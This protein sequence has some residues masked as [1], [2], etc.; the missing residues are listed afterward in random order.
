MKISFVGVKGLPYCGG[1]ERFTEEVGTRLVAKGHEVTVYTMRHYGMQGGMFQGMH[2]RTVPS[3]RGRSLEKLTSSFMASLYESFGGNAD[4]VHFHAFGPAAFCFIPRLMNRKVVV[5]G[6]GIEWQRSKWGAAGKLLLRLLE[7]PSVRFP[8]EV[9]VVSHVQ[10]EYLAEKYG[11]A[12]VYIPSGVNPP[13][14]E[15]PGLIKQYGLQGDDYILFAA[16]L[17]REK[18]LHYLIESYKRLKTDM[19]L[20]IAG[21]AEHESDYK[22]EIHRIAGGNE[23]IIF[24][25]FATGAL[26]R[27][28]LTNCH[29][30][31]LPSEIEGLSTALLEAMSYRNCC[32]VSDIPE[33]REALGGH[34][35]LFKNRD[36]DD[37]TEKLA[38][39]STNGNAANAC[40]QRAQTFALEQYSWEKIA[41]QYEDLYQGLLN[42]HGSGKR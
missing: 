20:V 18:G 23:K 41:G 15:K 12:S 34:G 38:F 4:I 9:T 8:H 39:L 2:I 19:K 22:A 11:R 17:V 32:L 30:F 14:F 13:E 3:V 24:T 27:E 29:V 16:R 35:Y 33:N 42:G 25:G 31:V 37:L 7:R 6:H 10:K 21:D 5:Q 1:I 28:L 26:F 36:I 40:K